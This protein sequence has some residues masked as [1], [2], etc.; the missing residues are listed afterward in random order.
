MKIKIKQTKTLVSITI[1][2]KLII[3]SAENKPDL[4]IKIKNKQ[5]FIDQFC[6]ELEDDNS[7][8]GLT[9]LQR[10]FDKIYEYVDEAIVDDTTNI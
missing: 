9:I 4:G 1:P 10:L 3:Y 2:K 8:D 6:K 5:K 7:E